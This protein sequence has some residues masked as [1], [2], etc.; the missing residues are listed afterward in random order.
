MAELRTDLPRV[1]AILA[2]SDVCDRV[3]VPAGSALLRVAPNEAMLVGTDDADGVRADVP[4]ATLVEV[5]SDAWTSLVLEGHDASEAFARVSELR[6]PEA[7][8]LQGEV[9][10]AA[11]K[12]I[13]EAGRITILVPA[14]LVA[15][16]EERIRADAAEVLIR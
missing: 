9:A 3:E 2:S 4:G 7:G 11:A 15:H 1:L 12:V 6:V 14:N 16:V 8:W 10:A 13:V 5:V